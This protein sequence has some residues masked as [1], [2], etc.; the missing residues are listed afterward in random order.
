MR[1]EFG[2]RVELLIRFVLVTVGGTAFSVFD[3]SNLGY[4]WLGLYLA[5]QAL[6][7]GLLANAPRTHGPAWL[8]FGVG[9]YALTTLL[10]LS[11]PLW[12]F[13]FGSPS[14][15]FCGAMGLVLGGIFTLWRD[16]APMLVL[17]FDIAL[18]LI[19]S[20]TTLWVFLPQ[21]ETPMGRFIAVLLSLSLATYYTMALIT[22]RRTKKRLRDA[23]RRG[24][25]AQKMEALGRLSGGVAHDFNN[26]LTVLQGSLELYEE[27]E[28]RHER[29]KLIREAYVSTQRASALVRQLLSF[30]RRAPLTPQRVEAD[31]VLD[32][33]NAMATRLL[34][35][36]IA[37]DCRS[38]DVRLPVLVDFDGL[39]SALLNLLINARDAMLDGGRITLRAE[40]VPAR[41]AS[42]QSRDLTERDY[43][44]FHVEDNGP[45]MSAEVQ[46][47]ALEPFFTT[48]E[49]GGGSGLGLPSAKGFAEQSGGALALT[50]QP[51][52]TRVTIYVPLAETSDVG[53]QNAQA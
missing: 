43:V 45:G 39:M 44:A 3:Q 47:K 38:P 29:D 5:S 17:P 12:L 15:A 30:A 40:F 16:D 41:Q 23:A 49:V 34:P 53:G 10:F 27:I 8:W 36:S 22:S 24:L 35:S 33:L 11:L 19:A 25:E 7:Y 32:T 9:A 51:R 2:D 37:V 26:I 46:S 6:A 48:K 18:G 14:A 13:A 52:S 4:V 50:S 20:A 42:R 28:D 31:D 21:M 1:Y